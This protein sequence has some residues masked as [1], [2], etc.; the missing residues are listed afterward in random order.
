[1]VKQDPRRPKLGFSGE[2][3]RI[4]KFWNLP[5]GRQVGKLGNL[6]SDRLFCFKIRQKKIHP[7][8]LT[9]AG[10]ETA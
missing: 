7:G 8:E 2:T 3:E 10:M 4:G 1:M 5:A 9:G 6:F